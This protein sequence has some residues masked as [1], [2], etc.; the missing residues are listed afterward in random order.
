[1]IP[2]TWTSN[3]ASDACV[4]ISTRNHTIDKTTCWAGPGPGRVTGVTIVGI[5][6]QTHIESLAEHVD[7]RDLPLPLSWSLP[8]DDGRRTSPKKRGLGHPRR[9]GRGADAIHVDGDR[10]ELVE[11]V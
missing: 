9:C 10:H 7:R 4:A 5:D 6:S 3:S 11:L 8:L 1:M 2:L